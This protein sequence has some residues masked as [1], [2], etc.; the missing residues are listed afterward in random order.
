VVIDRAY[1]S[2][3][4]YAKASFK[5]GRLLSAQGGAATEINAE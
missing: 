1:S 4:G 3:L 2:N 5:R